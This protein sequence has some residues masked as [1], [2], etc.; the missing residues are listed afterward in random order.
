MIRTTPVRRSLFMALLLAGLCSPLWA[1]PSVVSDPT[2]TTTVTHCAWYLDAAARE[3]L[4][5]PKD[6][7]GKPYCSKDL[8]AV[9]TGTHSIQ[10][11]FVIVDATWGNQ[12][13][14]KSDP[15]AFTRPAAPPKPLGLKLVP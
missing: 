9:T 4:V 12:E 7:T 11:A 15:F 3:Q 14:P 6:S 10:A 1:A 8:A 5:A 13:G 2:A